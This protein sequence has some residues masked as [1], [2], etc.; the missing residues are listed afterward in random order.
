MPKKSSF[1]IDAD[2]SEAQKLTGMLTALDKELNDP[3][4]LESLTDAAFSIME[5]SF[6]RDMAAVSLSQPEDYHHVYEPEQQGNPAAQLWTVK[7]RG[8]AGMRSISWDWKASHLTVPTEYGPDGEYRWE[9]SG[10]QFDPEKLNRVHVFVWRAPVM[11]YGMRVHVRPKLS[12]KRLLVFPNQEVNPG[13][14]RGAVFTAGGYSFTPGADVQG[15][16]T[17]FFAGWFGGGMAEQSLHDFEKDRD[18][19]FTRAY[20]KHMKT[21]GTPSRRFTVNTNGAKEG[22]RIAQLIAGE[23]KRDY[24]EMARQRRRYTASDEE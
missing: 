15:N 24:I 19:R 3:R 2:I 20:A 6:N 22:H 21:G 14:T 18:L 11:E 12:N 1:D 8:R 13:G 9:G 7:M 23:M 16:F 5:A 4:H 10:P 17:A